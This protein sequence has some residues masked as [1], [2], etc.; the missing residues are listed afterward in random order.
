MQIEVATQALFN[1]LSDNQ[2]VVLEMGVPTVVAPPPGKPGT[3]LQAPLP[4]A[5]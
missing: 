4:R 3:G 5:G 1:T 2:R